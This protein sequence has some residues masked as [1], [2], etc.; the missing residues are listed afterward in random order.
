MVEIDSDAAAAATHVPHRR[1]A[2]AAL[3][4]AGIVGP[5]L[6]AVVFV[7]QGLFRLGEYS[8]TAEP[9]SALEAGPNGWVQQANF[10]LFGVLTIAY[11]VGLHL[12]VRPSRA[13]IAGPAVIVLSGVG[14]VLAATFP[15]REDAAG[16]TYDPGGHY[17]VGLVFFLSIG[18]G[19]VAL[20]PRLARDPKWRALTG[21]TLLTGVALLVM[22]L[23]FGVLVVPDDAPLHRWAG[24][25][26]RF[27]LLVWFQCTL[28]LALRLLRVAKGERQPGVDVT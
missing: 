15:L 1:P 3:A 18:V 28:V 14:L 26:Q 24:L 11:A 13:G 17:L 20:S 16:L 9:V 2:V 19:L 8:P 25:A 12:G 21:Y 22:F 4:T 6:F 5:I 23:A 7:V 10:V 27:V